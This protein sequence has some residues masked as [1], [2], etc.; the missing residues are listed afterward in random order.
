[1]WAMGWSGVVVLPLEHRPSLCGATRHLATGRRAA[2]AGGARRG[3]LWQGKPMARQAYGNPVAEAVLAS[4]LARA[5][6]I[7]SG[8]H[9]GHVKGT[10]FE[11]ALHC[12]GLAARQAVPHGAVQRLDSGMSVRHVRESCR[13][14]TCLQH[15]N[16]CASVFTR[17]HALA[18]CP[19]V[20]MQKPPCIGRLPH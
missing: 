8:P 14:C 3:S 9:L 16:V 18:H 2:H 10:A 4:S 1:M 5:H 12:V 15:S 19:W 11:H 17:A 6:P 13:S 20:R 7:C